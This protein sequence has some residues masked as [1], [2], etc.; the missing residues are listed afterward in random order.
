MIHSALHSVFQE[1]ETSLNSCNVCCWFAF[2]LLTYLRRGKDGW[3]I[4]WCPFQFWPSLLQPP[5]HCFLGVVFHIP[6]FLVLGF[7]ESSSHPHFAG[8]HF[9]VSPW[10]RGFERRPCNLL[11]RLNV[12]TSVADVVANVAT[13]R[14]T[15][16]PHCSNYLPTEGI[17]T[18]AL[19]TL[20]WNTEK[21]R[22][23][24]TALDQ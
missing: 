22:E 18:L 20:F 21:S 13:H 7:T 17:C 1:L 5:L 6:W 2:K 19:R 4:T 9:Q 24:Y 10:E 11:F 8:V 14:I 3:R 16:Q 23:G 15:S 12:F